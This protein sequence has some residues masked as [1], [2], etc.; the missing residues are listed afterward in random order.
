MYDVILG[1][2]YNENS[3]L[4][5][6]PYLKKFVLQTWLTSWVEKMGIFDAHVILSLPCS[7]RHYMILPKNFNQW[8]D[9]SS[10]NMVTTIQ[11]LNRLFHVG[12]IFS[13]I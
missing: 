3:G 10:Q 2:I 12:K 13:H 4:D 5:I 6:L 1:K 11:N 8:N 9:L 7:F